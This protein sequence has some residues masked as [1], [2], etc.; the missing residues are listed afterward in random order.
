MSADKTANHAVGNGDWY[1]RYETAGLQREEIRGE[2]EVNRAVR[3]I[4]DDCTVPDTALPS[5]STSIFN[6]F[7][8]P[9]KTSFVPLPSEAPFSSPLPRKRQRHITLRPPVDPCLEEHTVPTLQKTASFVGS[10]AC[11]QLLFNS[12]PE[13]ETE[14]DSTVPLGSDKEERQHKN[15]RGLNYISDCC[16]NYSKIEIDR[17]PEELSSTFLTE[18]I[19]RAVTWLEADLVTQLLERGA[20]FENGGSLNVALDF[21]WSLEKR[22]LGMIPHKQFDS[23]TFLKLRHVREAEAI[24][25]HLLALGLS[26]PKKMLGAVVQAG[27]HAKTVDALRQA[28]LR[29]DAAD[30]AE[31]LY[32]LPAHMEK[33]ARKKSADTCFALIDRAHLLF[34][35]TEALH[36][37]LVHRMPDEL[38]ERLVEITPVDRAAFL[39]VK[40][41]TPCEHQERM[42]ALFERQL[43]MR[44]SVC[45]VVLMEMEEGC[46]RDAVQQQ[47][48]PH[49]QECGIEELHLAIIRKMPLKFIQNLVSASSVKPNLA[50]LALAAT[51]MRGTLYSSVEDYLETLRE[52]S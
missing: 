3:R 47:L 5:P 22:A 2:H 49:L 9:L 33:T 43:E 7:P 46:D 19:R 12:E 36:L 38:I 37:A 44:E 25:C 24:I 35:T 41:E 15:Q 20:G 45:A 16:N 8:S 21:G 28:G 1:R 26:L 23:S 52:S 42:I 17:L 10:T 29:Y 50:S 30:F 13:S 27:C 51:V 14:T 39:F 48:L 32:Q 18:L 40:Q 4:F 34:S 31:A 6:Y 11:R